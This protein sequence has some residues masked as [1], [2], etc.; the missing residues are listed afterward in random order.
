MF[1]ANVPYHFANLD[2]TQLP[3][4]W[5]AIMDVQ[6]ASRGQLSSTVAVRPR[7]IDFR[8]KAHGAFSRYERECCAVDIRRRGNMGDPNKTPRSAPRL[9]SD[10]QTLRKKMSELISLRERVAQA[11]LAVGVQLV[12]SAP[13]GCDPNEDDSFQG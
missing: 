3:I 5:L 8:Q 4:R 6:N 11:E 7:A 10:S 9:R 13:T 1:H 2:F 12:G